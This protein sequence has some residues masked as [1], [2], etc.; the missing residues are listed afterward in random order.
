[1]MLKFNTVGIIRVKRKQVPVHPPHA[2]SN[3]RACEGLH[4]FESS[5]S[6]QSAFLPGTANY[7]AESHPA[8]A[9]KANELHLLNR[10]VVLGAG[11]DLDAGQHHRQLQIFNVGGL[12]QQV[13]ASQL[14]SATS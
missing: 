14:I 8:F 11:V 6:R 3:Q 1:M 4:L 7:F 10:E 13:L 9:I 12:A 5:L 2:N